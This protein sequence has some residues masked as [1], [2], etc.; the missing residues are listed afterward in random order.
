MARTQKAHKLFMWFITGL[1]GLFFYDSK[2]S[3]LFF[4]SLHPLLLS[5][6]KMKRMRTRKSNL[7]SQMKSAY[8]SKKKWIFIHKQT[9]IKALFGSTVR[10]TNKAMMNFHLNIKISLK[11]SSEKWNKSWRWRRKSKKENLILNNVEH[12]NHW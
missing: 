7:I 10:P 9:F 2:I 5:W 3:V 11:I 6:K 12:V 8:Y 1:S 4:F